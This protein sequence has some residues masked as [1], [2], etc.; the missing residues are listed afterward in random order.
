[1]ILLLLTFPSFPFKAVV[2]Y[3][4][5]VIHEFF[6]CC[7]GHWTYRARQEL[8]GHWHLPAGYSG[9]AL[10]HRSVY[11]AAVKRQVLPHTHLHIWTGNGDRSSALHQ[12]ISFQPELLIDQ[13][14]NY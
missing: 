8:E 7:S 2:N 1:M 5:S 9:G 11:C 4:A 14:V 3:S 6:L 13:L 10:P 12:F